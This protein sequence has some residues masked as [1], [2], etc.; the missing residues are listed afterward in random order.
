MV[1]PLIRELR[2]PARARLRSLGEPPPHLSNVRGA[3]RAAGSLIIW[4]TGAQKGGH[5]WPFWHH[6]M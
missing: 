2:H 3:K 4:T 1:S 6:Q 5:D